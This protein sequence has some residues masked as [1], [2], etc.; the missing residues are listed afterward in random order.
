[1]IQAFKLSSIHFISDGATHDPH[2]RLVANPFPDTHL[3]DRCLSVLAI[4]VSHKP[5]YEHSCVHAKPLAGWS[6]ASSGNSNT[7]ILVSWQ[8]NNNGG[9]S[10]KN[11]QVFDLNLSIVTMKFSDVLPTLMTSPPYQCA[12]HFSDII[13]I[14]IDSDAVNFYMGQIKLY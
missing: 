1:L 5:A 4:G 13:S 7:G 2:D 14:P 3:F 6:S 10:A 11:G 12:M 8:P 9:L